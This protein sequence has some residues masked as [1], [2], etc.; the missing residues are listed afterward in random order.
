[1]NSMGKNQ[2][3]LEQEKIGTSSQKFKTFVVKFPMVSP[4]FAQIG[5]I[6]NL[7]MEIWIVVNWI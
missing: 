7:T 2:F 4:N 1:M 6:G 5:T 3:G